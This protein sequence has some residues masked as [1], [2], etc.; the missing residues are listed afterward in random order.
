MC[1]QN[2]HLRDWFARSVPVYPEWLSI[3][4]VPFV[5]KT[6]L[7]GDVL[8]AGDAAGMI[9]PLAGDGMAMALHSGRLAALL[10]DRYLAKDLSAL[11]L[12][13]SYALAW[14][15]NYLRRLRLGQML[16]AVMLRPAM[17]TSGLHLLNLFPALGNF[18]VTQTRDMGLVKW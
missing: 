6:S 2:A 10:M 17:L 15:A 1:T 9:V 13:K 3:A 8:L 4:Q 7:E 18:L 5:S 16:Q 12:K 11:E 14:N